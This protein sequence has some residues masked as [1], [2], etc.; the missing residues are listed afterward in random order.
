MEESFKATFTS[1]TIEYENLTDEAIRD[2]FDL[3]DRDESGTVSFDE[4]KA[5]LKAIKLT[6]PDDELR[7]LLESVDYNHDGVL[8]LSEFRTLV[9]RQVKIDH[10]RKF[11]RDIDQN[12]DGSLTKD[13][14]YQVFTAGGYKPEEAEGLVEKAI[15]ETDITQ[16]G[17]IKFEGI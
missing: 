7:R 13:E 8:N 17:K 10:L 11:F 3:L 4:L 9:N 15:Q 5:A 14:L 16:E 12:S 2:A 6:P 1:I